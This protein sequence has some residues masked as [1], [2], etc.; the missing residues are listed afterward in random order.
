M[1]SGHRG[2]ILQGSKG[3]MTSPQETPFST[4]EKLKA[5]PTS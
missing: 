4:V 3:H 1:E 2:N 5:S